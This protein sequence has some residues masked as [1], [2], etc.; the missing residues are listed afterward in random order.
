[1]WLDALMAH[2]PIIAPSENEADNMSTGGLATVLMCRY[3]D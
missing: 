2:I 3:T 1:M